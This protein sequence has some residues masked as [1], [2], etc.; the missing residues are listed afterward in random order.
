MSDQGNYRYD[1]FISYSHADRTWV[2]EKLLPRLEQ[3]GLRVCI[4]DRDFEIGTPSLVN[5][6]RAAKTSKHTLAVLTPAWVESEWTEFESLLV[7]VTG[8][9]ARRRR[10]LPLMLKACDLPDRIATLTYA[11][12]VQ[13]PPNVDPFERLLGQLQND[14]APLRPITQPDSSPFIVGPP[15]THPRYFFG[16]ERELKRLFVC[17]EDYRC[18]MPRSLDRD[19]AE[20]LH[21]SGIS[22]P[23]PLRRQ[24]NYAQDNGGI[25]Y[26]NR[27]AT[28]GF[29]SISKTHVYIIE[30]GY[31]AI[32]SIVSIYHFPLRV[33][34]TILLTSR[35]VVCVRQQ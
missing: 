7:G 33:T 4:D 2:W 3:V 12:F 26:H 6:E 35:A 1:V 16:R 9:A 32:C 15:I 31:C 11:D 14:A 30:K 34:L 25:G 18:K 29:L 28:A 5:M 22:K 8:P 23:L 13:P 10:L 27:N 19:E 21:C 24:N 17:G 20:R